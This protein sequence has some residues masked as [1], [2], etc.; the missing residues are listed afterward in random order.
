[1]TRT[2]IGLWLFGVLLIVLLLAAAAFRFGLLGQLTTKSR[3]S[4]EAIAALR[5]NDLVHL[6]TERWIVF[7]PKTGFPKT[8]LIFYPCALCDARA[9]VPLTRRI[10]EA[11]FLTV[12]VPMPSNFAIFDYLRAIDVKSRYPD[13]KR[14]VLGG[15][16]M[17][18]GAAAMF[19][20]AHPDWADGLLMWDSY[21]N[22]DYDISA[23]SLP[24]LSIYANKHHAPDRPQ[25]FEQAKQYLPPHTRYQVIDGS[26]HFQFGA[27]HR[28]DIAEYSTGTL[29]L[30]EHHRQLLSYS[31]TFLRDIDQGKL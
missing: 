16:S 24:V 14:W 19:L 6:N 11:G 28:D 1:M 22:G 21:S 17:G 4:T 31:I 18:G 23:Q 15:H 20:K 13:I 2:R 30:A 7:T 8:G 27:F 5:G 9:F 10:A 26:D 12:I 29:P 3:A 25:R